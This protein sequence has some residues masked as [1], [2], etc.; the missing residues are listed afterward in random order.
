[1]GFITVL[2]IGAGIIGWALYVS[3]LLKNRKYKRLISENKELKKK[4]Q[5][6]ALL[7]ISQRKS[8]FKMKKNSCNS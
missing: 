1:V 2:V 5:K 8:L 3:V 7:I 4:N 6:Q